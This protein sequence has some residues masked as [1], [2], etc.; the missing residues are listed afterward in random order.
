MKYFSIELSAVSPLAIRSDHAPEEAKTASYIPGTT[1]LGGLAAAYRLLH[2][3]KTS[4]FENLFLS[5][6]ISFPNLYPADFKDSA[7]QNLNLPVYPLPKTAQSCKRFSGFQHRTK[8]EIKDDV[9]RHGV[10]DGL[11][12][13]AVFTLCSNQNDSKTALK[14]LRSRR[15]CTFKRPDQPDG[16]DPC[17]ETMDHFGGYYCRD[18]LEPGVIFLADT[19][20]R[21][22]THTGINRETGTV[23]EGIL[24]N[25]QVFDEGMRFWGM[26]Q[27]PDDEELV[28]QFTTFME[29]VSLS[30]AAAGMVRIGTGRSRGLG[31]VTLAHHEMETM[32]GRLDSCDSRLQALHKALDK[33]L[34]EADLPERK[35]F[36]FAL[37]LHSPSIVY[38]KYMRCRG[39]IDGNTLAELVGDDDFPAS[40]FTLLYQCASTQRVMGWNEL[41]GMPKTAEY[42]IET[43]SV[44]LFECNQAL[45]DS[46]LKALFRLE[47]QGI[48]RRRSEGFGRVC[49][50]DPFHLETELL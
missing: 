32:Q 43:G 26:A 45:D 42:A 14:A 20:T 41:W 23:Q 18:S 10:R 19:H 50:S 33:R 2:P 34:R 7:V 22:Q 40:T 48:G 12:D 38:D 27:L 30:G 4:E 28:S 21:V 24:Y 3:E 47:E 16:A 37:T 46:L 9:E 31:K 35:P 29:E 39:T 15:F 13:W 49:L 17:L 36:Y 1:L 11:L 6:K 8:Q 44:F 25:R 5:S